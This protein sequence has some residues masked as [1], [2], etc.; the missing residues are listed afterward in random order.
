MKLFSF[1]TLP[2]PVLT[3]CTSGPIV[4]EVMHNNWNDLTVELISLTGGGSTL[5]TNPV[6]GGYRKSRCW[7]HGEKANVPTAA[8]NREWS[9]VA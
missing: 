9:A 2:L 5:V 7:R 1:S 8:N 6:D 3:A 4:K